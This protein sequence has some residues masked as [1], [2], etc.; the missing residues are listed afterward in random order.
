[1]R[2]L[3]QSGNAQQEFDKLLG[4]SRVDELGNRKN[5]YRAWEKCKKEGLVDKMGPEM[6]AILS[7]YLFKF[8]NLIAK[9]E[10]MG[11]GPI[12]WAPVCKELK[13]I[14]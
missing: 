3:G 11:G 9:N 10:E 4:K 5:K 6:S 12:F 2:I 14:K 7:T 13:S 8:K 1:M